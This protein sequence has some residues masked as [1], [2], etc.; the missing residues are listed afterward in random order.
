MKRARAARPGSPERHRRRLG[1]GQ[2][3]L[4]G[5]IGLALCGCDEDAPAAPSEERSTE[6]PLDPGIARMVPEAEAARDRAIE[7]LLEEPELQAGELWVMQRVARVSGHDALGKRIP[8]WVDVARRKQPGRVV[9]V[10]PSA[11]RPRVPEELSMGIFRLQEYL[12][13]SYS[14]PPGVALKLVREF[15]SQPGEGY[16]AT[17]QLLT[18]IWWEEVRGTPVPRSRDDRRRL[19]DV[20]ARDQ[21]EDSEFSDLYAERA[22]LLGF[23]GDACLADLAEWARVTLDAQQGDGLWG[24]LEWTLEYDGVEYSSSSKKHTGVVGVGALQAFLDAAGDP[25]RRCGR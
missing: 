20:L 9:L 22:F 11:Q 16:V 24:E 4:L 17:H 15:L 19:L 13:A 5:W 3:V 12:K 23:Y 10:D 1:T 2:V 21:T 7:A 8:E 18:L 25:S 6:A 14:D